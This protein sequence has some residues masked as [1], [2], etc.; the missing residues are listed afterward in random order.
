M[1]AMTSWCVCQ[2][3]GE[4]LPLGTSLP[5]SALALSR[6]YPHSSPGSQ[7][8]R[9][10]G[11][12]GLEACDG[13]EVGQAQS[14][15]GCPLESQHR[16]APLLLLL[17]SLPHLTHSYAIPHC[18]DPAMGAAPCQSSALRKVGPG[19]LGWDRC[20]RGETI[21]VSWS[22]LG[23]RASWIS[24][25]YLFSPLFTLSHSRG[26]DSLPHPLLQPTPLREGPV[27]SLV[28]GLG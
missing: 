21:R 18:P 15:A 3:Q 28:L 20:P 7:Q 17:L 12:G 25:P 10:G 16:W 13:S 19:A 1:M 14:M 23:Y 24:R 2:A 5:L 11:T 8:G 6:L 4:R 26:D 9:R 27:A 22:A